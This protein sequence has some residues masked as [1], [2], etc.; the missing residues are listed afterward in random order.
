ML[1]GRGDPCNP[2]FPVMT[3][4]RI[5]FGP[6]PIGAVLE[7]P[8]GELAFLWQAYANSLERERK[9]RKQLEK[10]NRGK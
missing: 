3:V 9:L 4:G 6:A 5:E 7:R 8:K 2:T 1:S 10:K